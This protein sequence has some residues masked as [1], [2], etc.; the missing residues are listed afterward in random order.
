MLTLVISPPAATTKAATETTGIAAVNLAVIADAVATPK[1]ATAL[2]RYWQFFVP[3]GTWSISHPVTK[4]RLLV[5][6][7]TTSKAF[8]ILHTR[9][10]FM[11]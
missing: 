2:I 7:L 6:Y 11:W 10:H 9:I 1:A 5:Q 8:T 4:V 3:F